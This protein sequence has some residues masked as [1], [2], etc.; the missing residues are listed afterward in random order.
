MRKVSIGLGAIAAIVALAAP[1]SALAAQQLTL[2][3][4][5][6]GKLGGSGSILFAFTI[7]TNPLGGIP[8][9]LSG[10]VIA[11]LPKGVTYASVAA[12]AKQ[13]PTC[14]ATLINAATG[15]TPPACPAGSLVGSGTSTF[16][17]QLGSQMLNE[18]STIKTYLS[19]AN[20]IQLTFWGNGVSPIAE[21]KVFTGTILPDSGLFGEKIVTN[22]PTITTVPGGP[23][24]SVTEFSLTTGASIKVKKK[25][26]GKT[27]T[28]TVDFIPLPTK[29]TNPLHWSA[30]AS[31]EDG[32]TTTSTATSA[33]P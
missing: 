28:T 2:T 30:T 33:C 15:S 23:D 21:T 19:S 31:Y 25:V 32:S 20:P 26:H 14:S 18:P 17:A 9:P 16:Q 5:L 27:K 11:E 3:P 29:C 8:S 4:K 10:Q 24:A 13:F 6:T 1:A 12:S 22:V 7:A